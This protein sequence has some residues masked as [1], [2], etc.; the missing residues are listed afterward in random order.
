MAEGP[1]GPSLGGEAGGP[2]PVRS[3]LGPRALG[4]PG[5]G[6]RA[7]GGEET[8]GAPRPAQLGCLQR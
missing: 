6:P 1:E 7:G 2:E 3:T 4:G 5:G 8:V